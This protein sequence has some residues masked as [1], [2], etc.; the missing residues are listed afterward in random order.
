MIRTKERRHA[1]TNEIA[2]IDRENQF[3]ARLKAECDVIK[4]YTMTPEELAK[5]DRM[6]MN[7]ADKMS[8]VTRVNSLT[9]KKHNPRRFKELTLKE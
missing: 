5:Y 1:R 7:T 2:F 6:K 9:L 4:T 3:A 8:G